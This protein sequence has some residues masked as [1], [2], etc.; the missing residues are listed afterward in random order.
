LRYLPYPLSDFGSSLTGFHELSILI[1]LQIIPPIVAAL[2]T[3]FAVT[4]F[5]TKILIKRGITGIDIHKPSRTVCAEMGGL[6]V[7]IGFISG[8]AAI[9]LLGIP[10]PSAL[11]AAVLTICL[12]AG[13][14]MLD[15][16]TDMRQRNKVWLIGLASLPLMLSYGGSGMVWFPLVGEVHLGIAY[17]LLLIP[18][19]IIT[20][21]NFT[22]MHA[23]FNGLEAGT[24]LIGLSTLGTACLIVG[25]YMAAV[26][27]V[28]LAGTYG[29][30]LVYNWFPAR[31]FPGD[32]GTLMSGAAIAAIGIV[33]KLEFVAIAVTA[34]AAIDFTLK[35]ISRRPFGQR[36]EYG[37]STVSVDGFLR[38]APYPSLSHAF[39]KVS[40]LSEKQLVKALLSMEVLYSTI[41]LGL[42]VLSKGF[43]VGF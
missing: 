22:N 40:A 27:A 4:P 9:F 35:L 23:G 16:L 39:M 38:P 32:V 5:L 8:M 15:D 11:W 42:L 34:P 2:V 13:V 10:L 36:V 20:I 18:L 25:E 12:V 43:S 14:G 7:L 24:A 41:A 19:Q 26:L 29:G 33:A 3:T 1:G 6:A 28:I 17:L 30:F 31:I 37:N 21:S